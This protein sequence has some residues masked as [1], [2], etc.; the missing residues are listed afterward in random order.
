[1]KK[2]TIKAKEWHDGINGN[3]YYATH[4]FIDGELVLVMPF[5][6]GYGDHSLDMSFRGLNDTGL[7]DPPRERYKNGGIEPV[8]QYK[9]RIGV[10]VEYIKG[11]CNTENGLRRYGNK[12][13]KKIKK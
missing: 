10:E 4:C 9:Q 2:I 8:W 3:T 11:R 12:K 5:D 6:Y 13:V 1:M 7:L